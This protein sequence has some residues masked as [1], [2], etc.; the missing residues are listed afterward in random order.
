M[1]YICSMK[2]HSVLVGTAILDELYI[3]HEEAFIVCRY[4]NS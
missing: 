4:C 1:N 3:Q 2:R